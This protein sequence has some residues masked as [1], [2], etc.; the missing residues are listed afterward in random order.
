MRMAA[1]ATGGG[2]LE[3]IDWLVET[4]S[5]AIVEEVFYSLNFLFADVVKGAY[6]GKILPEQTVGVF[7]EPSF[8]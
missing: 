2:W 5:G 4:F 1:S 6:F 8:P 7:V 3:D